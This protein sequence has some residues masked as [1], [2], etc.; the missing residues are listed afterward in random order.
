MANYFSHK[1]TAVRASGGFYDIGTIIPWT[2]ATVL[3]GFLLCD[4]SSRSKTGEYAALFAVI[5]TTYGTGDSNDGTTFSLPNLL[6]RSIVGE[7]TS[8]DGTTTRAFNI[9]ESSGAT[10]VTSNVSFP[11]ATVTISGTNLNA[12]IASAP[13]PIP[14]HSH[15]WS[16]SGIT[17]GIY[18]GSELA[19]GPQRGKAFGFRLGTQM[20]RDGPN[21]NVR[22]IAAGIES[23]AN[24]Q[25]L[26]D[27]SPSQSTNI[28]FLQV[29]GTVASFGSGTG[30]H[31]HDTQAVV[32]NVSF[33][34][35]NLNATNTGSTISPY[36]VCRYII[37]AKEL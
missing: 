34:Q 14:A 36:G 17:G 15:N 28:A 16:Q 9:G 19:S 22:G 18:G 5:D 1:S 4:G 8:N 11:S 30:V 35:T 25:N 23:A 2:K 7:G 29:S 26:N 33:N 3:D 24:S 27:V 6:G 31:N 13:V 10:N 12:P 37:K 21:N 32:G 20:S